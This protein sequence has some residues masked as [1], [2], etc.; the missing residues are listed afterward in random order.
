MLEMASAGAKYAT[1]SVAM[2]MSHNVKL[3]VLSSFANEPGTMVVEE[4]ENME[5]KNKWHSYSRDEAKVT[6]VGLRT[7]QASP[8]TC[9]AH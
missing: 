6:L 5:T 3:Q 9:L 4:D 2:A 1:R 8:Q 7:S